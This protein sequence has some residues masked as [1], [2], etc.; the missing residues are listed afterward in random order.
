MLSKYYYIKIF[1]ISDS[2]TYLV[3]SYMDHNQLDSSAIPSHP[4]HLCEDQCLLE[5][6]IIAN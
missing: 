3:H 2:A 4:L 6:G 1:F 5:L